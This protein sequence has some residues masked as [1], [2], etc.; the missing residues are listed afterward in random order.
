M[1]RRK[2]L[3]LIRRAATSSCPAPR[4]LPTAPA[5]SWP[6]TTTATWRCST[7]WP[8]AGRAAARRV[9]MRAGVR[10]VGVSRDAFFALLDDGRLVSW[11]EA[12][13]SAIPLMPGVASFAAA[14][15]AGSPS[16]MRRR[17]GMAAARAGATARCRGRGRR[18]HRR[19]CRLLHPPRRHALGQGPGAPRPVR[20]RT[21]HRHGR[22]RQHRTRR[23]GREGAHRACALPEPATAWSWAP[24][25]TVSGRWVRTAWATRPIA[26]AACSTV[27]APSPPA[28]VIRWPSAPTAACGPGAKV[29]ASNRAGCSRVRGVAAGDTATIALRGRQPVAVGW[30]QA[31]P[32]R[33]A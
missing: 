33:L 15:R 21:A 1:Q 12:P 7:A 2:F 25:A 30:R 24:A 18:L 32:L 6:R 11:G 23:G 22:L 3:V 8:T 4:P 9:R 17:C 5:R 26:G 16:T 10:Q 28:R 27:R 20:R 31:A 19:Q 13:D 14:S 29:S